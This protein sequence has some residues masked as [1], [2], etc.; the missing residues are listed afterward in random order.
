MSDDGEESGIAALLARA[1]Y[2][3]ALME[4]LK[5]GRA[6]RG[7][8]PSGSGWTAGRSGAGLR[9][10][11]DRL[12]SRCNATTSTRNWESSTPLFW[13]Y[14]GRAFRAT[15]GVEFALM[16][17]RIRCLLREFRAEMR[18]LLDRA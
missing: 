11:I 2:R 1:S 8:T 10:S 15:G 16:E 12:G 9:R 6:A 3:G 13:H 17:T 5:A 14:L 18:L 7:R 4:R